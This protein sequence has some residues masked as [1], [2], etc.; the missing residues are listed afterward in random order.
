M[1]NPLNEISKVYLEQVL[2]E[3]EI[4]AE[5]VFQELLEEGF[6][7]SDL[8]E[9]IDGVLTEVSSSYY[10][11]A[12]KSSKKKSNELK[13]K[14][15]MSKVRSRLSN[16]QVAAYNK[17][18]ELKQKAGDTINK[19]KQSASAGK[20]FQA[21]K[22]PEKVKKGLKGFIKKQAEKVVD[23]MSEETEVQETVMQMSPAEVAL[24]KKRATVDQQIAMKRKQALSK[25]KK[26]PEQVANK[27]SEDYSDWRSDLIEVS[28]YS[29]AKTTGA[30]PTKTKKSE[31]LDQEITVKNVKNKV[32][33]NPNMRE[34]FASMGAEVLEVSEI[35]EK[36][37]MRTAD[38]GDVVKDFYKSDA[39]QF[40]GKSKEK[41]RQMAIAAKLE[42]EDQNEEFTL[43]DV[44]EFLVTE[45]YV[46]DRA[47]AEKMLEE[48]SETEMELIFETFIN[49]A[50]TDKEGNDKFDRYKRMVRHKQDK[51]GVS[52]LKQRLMTGADHNIDNEKKAKAM[53]ECF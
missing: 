28:G 33:I 35:D 43:E 20:V 15:F 44:I 13:R 41:R 40:K 37:N 22:A 38:V 9:A 21:K 39:P 11:S 25:I 3:E 51:Y 29:Y 34:E 1:N 45:G 5:S 14:E 50:K 46:W 10:D 17:G 26:Q 27:M 30:V 53:G 18:R 16:A 19:A 24:Q 31:E 23:R 12:V 36:I 8:R 52:T 47:G 32:V 4:V 6:E 7:E 49:E 48:A 42:A 2:S